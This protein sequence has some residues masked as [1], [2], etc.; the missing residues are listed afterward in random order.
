MST[1][2]KGV[3]HINTR[4]LLPNR[5]PFVSPATR[6]FNRFLSTPDDSGMRAMLV[7]LPLY[8]GVAA[9]I[10]C[11]MLLQTWEPSGITRMVFTGTFEVEACEILYVLGLETR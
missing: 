2:N 8:V 9:P 4:Y 3:V 7:P 11:A 5:A 6:I 10:D 1:R